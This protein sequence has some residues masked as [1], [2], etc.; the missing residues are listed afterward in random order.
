[1]KK[2]IFYPSSCG[3][4]REDEFVSCRGEGRFIINMAFGFSLL[5]YECYI[6]N[7]VKQSPKK[8]WNNVYIC[9]TSDEN[10]TYEYAISFDN[11]LILNRK[12]YRN[13]IVISY[14]HLEKILEYNKSINNEITIGFPGEIPSNNKFVSENTQVFPTVFPV[15]SVSPTFVPYKY[16]PNFPELKIYV[17][18]S[19]WSGSYGSNYA[20][21]KQ[22]L[23]LE[24]LKSNGYKLNLSI[25]GESEKYK[26]DLLDVYKRYSN[27]I[28]YV[29]NEKCNY[30][31]ILNTITEND[32][33]I[34]TGA[35]YNHV[36]SFI[37]DI[38]GLGK[39]VIYIVNGGHHNGTILNPLY[40][41]HK[42]IIVT[43]ESDEDSHK[44]L[45]EI[46]ND[47]E[48]YYNCF[49]KQLNYY[50]FTYWKVIIRKLLN[51]QSNSLVTKEVRTKY[52]D[53]IKDLLKSK[54]G[55]NF[56][57]IALQFTMLGTEEPV[58]YEFSNL[59]LNKNYN[60][61]NVV[62]FG[63]GMSTIWFTYLSTLKNINFI[64]FEHEEKWLNE[65]KKLIK[66]SINYDNPNIK[67][68]DIETKEL[69]I[70]FEKADL[71]FVDG[72]RRVGTLSDNINMIS[73]NTVIIADDMAGDFVQ[74]PYDGALA[75]LGKNLGYKEICFFWSRD[76]V[77]AILDKKSRFNKDEQLYW[78]I[79]L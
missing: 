10:I 44:K 70:P 55:L 51:I 78:S 74:F 24:Y 13:K 58:L 23:I 4:D 52:A 5:G 75:E 28:N 11:C 53:K 71:I 20:R 25:H 1:M 67:L 22:L 68:V 38:I 65:C 77:V 26:D 47:L 18:D 42:K 45:D 31:D 15:S 50:N 60:I 12:N 54:T 61:N 73:D 41:C 66:E 37:N 34:P 48:S 69:T 2:A 33:C 63:C 79:E 46:F 21:Q 43:Q 40:K 30:K 7:K 16:E 59:I 56:T 14:A 57:K 32:L 19:T 8:I 35:G 3:Y 39:P 9:N 29:N 62:E 49:K 27:K 72:L 36:G 6:I 76:R 17:I 64:S